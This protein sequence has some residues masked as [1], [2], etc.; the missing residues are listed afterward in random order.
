M[1][2]TRSIVYILGCFLTLTAC[3]GVKK[4]S[5]S[6]STL[7]NAYTEGNL[8]Y[9]SQFRFKYLFFESQR[10][11]ALEDFSKAADLM[12]QCIAI[13]PLNADANFELAQL[14]MRTEQL[15]S[16]LFYANQAYSLDPT[17]SWILL[18]LAQLNLALGNSE[19]ELNAYKALVKLD[20]FNIEQQ[21]SL[22]QAYT[23]NEQYKKAIQVYQLIEK[24]LG[25]AE[26]LSVI[27][28]RLYIALGN[29]KSAAEEL[30]KLIS[31]FPSNVRYRGML[32]ELYQANDLPEKALQIYNDI[33]T[34]NPTEPRA[35]MALADHYRLKNDFEKV[36]YHLNNCFN[37]PSFSKDVKLQILISYFQ[38]AIETP[39]Y[40]DSWI[41]LLDKAILHHPLE[42]GFYALYGDLFYQKNKVAESYKAYSKALDL[43][44]TEYFIW[45]RCLLMALE[46]QLYSD[47]IS[48]GNKAIELNPVQPM[49]Y[50]FTGLA[51][52]IDKQQENAVLLLN[53]GLNYVV[54]N[55]P[56]KAEFYNYLGDAYHSLQLNQLSDESYENAL[57][58]IPDNPI[59]LNNYS[60]YLSV[61]EVELEKAKQY[62][63]L[64]NELQPDVATYQ[65][66]YGWILYKLGLYTEASDWLSKAVLNSSIESAVIL[67]HYADALYQNGEKEEALRYWLK[68]ISIGGNSSLLLKKA[69]DGILYE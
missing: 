67:E 3:T 21:Y 44:V 13:D 33:L 53:K 1:R 4:L 59:V 45:N 12:E 64:C 23:S 30:H 8:S 27:K 19:G 69:N 2:K 49:L 40:S 16:A 36:F 31:A 14:Y 25:V 42:S 37:N 39:S 11:K 22:A 29:L 26:E 48:K 15:T 52:S 41:S 68:A 58:L 60:Y 57:A 18:N 66:T 5:S 55:R 51:Y 56:L 20:P 17:N 50:L 6:N 7:L 46:L 34:V 38:L 62:S 63:K 47:V 65:D 24:R 9:K 10:L 61:R 43:G 35:N 54:N 28:E 32:A